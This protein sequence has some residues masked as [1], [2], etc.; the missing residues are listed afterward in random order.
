MK[1]V[2]L[3]LLGALVSQVGN[4]YVESALNI[5]GLHRKPAADSISISSPAPEEHAL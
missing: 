4:S 3:I 2:A 1:I 5:M